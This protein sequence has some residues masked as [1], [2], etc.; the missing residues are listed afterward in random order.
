MYFRHI[1]FIV[2][3]VLLFSQCDKLHNDNS[4]KYDSSFKEPSEKRVQITGK[5]HNR[6]VY[7]HVQELS[8]NI[9]CLLGS[10]YTRQITSPILDDN[11]FHFDF[12]LPQP[13]DI[14]MNPYLDFLYLKPGDSIH[15]DLDFKDL[16]RTKLSGKPTNTAAI[17]H[18]FCKYFENTFYRK[19]DYGIGTNCSLNCPLEE[20]LNKL[21]ETRQNHHNRRS[22]FLQQNKVREEVKILTESMIELDYYVELVQIMQTRY[23]QNKSIIEPQL[24]MKELNEQITKHFDSGLYS[25]SHFDFIGN[26][27]LPTLHKNNQLEPDENT[28]DWVKRTIPNNTVKNFAFATMAGPALIKKDLDFFQDLYA[29]IDQEYLLERLMDEYQLIWFGINNPEFV[30]GG[31]LGESN[32]FTSSSFEKD[33]NPLPKLIKQN[34]GKVQ[35]ID[36]WTTWCSP[37]ISSLEEYKKLMTQYADKEVEFIFI[38]AN[39]TSENY[40]KIIQSKGMNKGHFYLCSQEESQS[41]AKIFQGLSFPYGILVNKKGV[42]VDYGRHVRPELGLAAKIDHLLKYNKLF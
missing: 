42:I 17:N 26:A 31:I 10:R 21:N 27:Y 34:R 41:L 3:T 36:I 29:E 15:I 24:L 35:V 38:C 9:S 32:D 33:V 20:V 14:Y 16:T 8:I 28:I 6:E 18:Q 13:Q 22:S 23:A 25:A 40:D 1:I 19:S 37:C 12:E 2:L 7:S 5:I 30:S 39:S 4:L 11:T